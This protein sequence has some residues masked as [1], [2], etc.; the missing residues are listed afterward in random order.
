MKLSY[1]E[2]KASGNKQVQKNFIKFLKILFA[3]ITKIVLLF[4]TT[5]LFI[6]CSEK[7]PEN[8]VLIKG[9][10]FINQNSNFF[11][12]KIVIPSFFIGKYEVTQKEWKEIMSYNPSHFVGDS[13]P[14]EMVSWYE[15]LEYCN[16]KSLKEGLKPYY[17]IDKNKKDKNNLNNFDSLKWTITINRDANGYRLPTESE[18]E[19]AAS[20]GQKSK[21]F[22]YSGS[23]NIDEVAWYWQNSGDKY[24]TCFWS[25]AVLQSN[26]NR[27]RNVGSKKPNELGLFDMSG[28][29]REWCWDIHQK[30]SPDDF[31]GRIWKGGGWIGGDFCCEPKFHASLEASG[32]G[33]DQGFR[34][35]RNK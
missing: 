21:N 22:K 10:K 5:T 16:A 17:K 8:M 3:Q 33:P 26:H 23:D 4:T 20:G 11:G 28:N 32:K 25:W 34:V 29:V 19:Y 9:G 14:V 18:W 15:C 31:Q 1:F 27:T 2:K 24:L 6:A 35:C 13:L 7:S 12:S 30:I